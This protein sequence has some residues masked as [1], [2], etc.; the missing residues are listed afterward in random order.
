MI[1]VT[2]GARE[3]TI[4]V[5]E[6]I[7]SWN[8][9]LKPF[10]SVRGRDGEGAGQVKGIQPQSCWREG[11]GL[12]QKLLRHLSRGDQTPPSKSLVRQ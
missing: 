3:P 2:H 7:L 4:L 5:V 11:L 8:L 1:L 6:K 9:Q 12:A 10:A